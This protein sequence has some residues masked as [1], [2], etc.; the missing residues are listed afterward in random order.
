V[1]A[2]GTVLG[3]HGDV[4]RYFQYYSSYLALRVSIGAFSKACQGHSLLGFLARHLGREQDG[5]WAAEERLCR[6]G[7]GR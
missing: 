5:C 1:V 7:A 3:H 4:Q 6:A 2:R